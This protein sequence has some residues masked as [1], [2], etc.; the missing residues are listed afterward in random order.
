MLRPSF[1]LGKSSLLI[2]MQNGET[3]N[4]WYAYGRSKTANML[5]AIS[6]ARKLGPGRGFLA[7]SVHPGVIL[8]TSLASHIGNT[9]F[10]DLRESHVLS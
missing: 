8:D 9:D 1:L 6:L 2:G 4:K 5:F 3:Y 7:F 10:E